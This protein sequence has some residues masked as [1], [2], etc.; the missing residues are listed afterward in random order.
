LLASSIWPAA[1]LPEIAG[2]A[3]FEGATAVTVSVA[4]EVA[5]AEPAAFDAVTV[6]SS[7]RPPSALETV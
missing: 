3:V 2:G 1:A 7:V 6:A 5:E 4:A